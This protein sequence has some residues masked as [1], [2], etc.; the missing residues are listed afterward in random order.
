MDGLT[1]V[2]RLR[3]AGVSTPILMMSAPADIQI[4]LQAMRLGAQD[5]I[6]KPFDEEPLIEKLRTLEKRSAPETDAHGAR[7][8]V[9]TLT[10]REAQVMR[11][12]VTGASNKLVAEKL[13]IS[14]KTVE[15]HRARVMK[16][17][18]AKTL[19]HLVRIAI[20]SEQGAAKPV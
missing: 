4:A 15:M 5:F 7:Q 12:V 20:A 18:G 11:E 14:Q 13:G 9:A 2:S 1:L 8:L 6:E 19:A 3:D 17:T 10:P 16:K